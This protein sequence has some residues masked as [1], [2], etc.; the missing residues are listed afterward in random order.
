[1]QTDEAAKCQAHTT[2]CSTCKS[3]N[4]S[5]GKVNLRAYLRG[6]IGK[7]AKPRVTKGFKEMRL[8]AGENTA[9]I[10]LQHSEEDEEVE[11]HFPKRVKACSSLRISVRPGIAGITSALTSLSPSKIV[12]RS[13]LR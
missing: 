10:R 12:F 3:P 1:M 2:C 8:R 9:C 6:R 13:A 7:S 4:V 5:T 11:V